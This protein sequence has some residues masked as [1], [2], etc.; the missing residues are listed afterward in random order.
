[1]LNTLVNA[2]Q[3]NITYKTNA[4]IYRLRKLPLI[5]K[6]IPPAL[7]KTEGLKIFVRVI[8]LLIMVI[9]A[10]LSKAIYIVLMLFLPLDSLDIMSPNAIITLTVFL[11]LIGAI[12]NTTILKADTKKYYAVI[13]LRMEASSYAISHFLF[14]L[15]KTF[16]TFLP[17]LMLLIGLNKGNI[18]LAIP[19]TFFIVEVKIIGEALELAY[20]KKHKKLLSTNFYLSIFGGLLSVSLGLGLSY[21]NICISPLIL[22]ILVTALIPLFIKA[23][24]YIKTYHLYNEAYKKLITINTTVFAANQ[25]TVNIV[26]ERSRIDSKDMAVNSK[27]NK[28]TGYDY[29]NALFF[30]RHKKILL[31]SSIK[32]SLIFLGIVTFVFVLVYFVPSIKNSLNKTLMTF[33]PYFVFIM[34]LTNRGAVVTQA[35]FINCDNSM[36]TYK[37]YRDRKILLEVFKQRLLTII[38]INLIPASVLALALPGLLYLSGGT[39]NPFTY[40]SLFMAIIFMSIFFSV[41]HLVIYYLLQPYDINM[42]EKSHIFQVVNSL[43]YLLCYFCMQLRVQTFI[44]SLGTIFITFLYIIIALILVYI[45][46]PKTFKLK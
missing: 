38:S 1:M 10:F 31:K 19:L 2:Y 22:L 7:Y 15:G 5:G 20:F 4:F 35:M 43:T 37:F 32:T 14:N 27:I 26:K 25:N 21:L 44:F 28:K 42:S 8:V 9:S 45:Y 40:I 11:S 24:S 30:S 41:H 34:Y 12:I 13:L 36:L 29:F 39:S 23:F 33:L 16:I 17:G 46:A 18:L 6:F 3:I